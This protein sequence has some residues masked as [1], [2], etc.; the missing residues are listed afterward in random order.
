MEKNSKIIER[1]MPTKTIFRGLINVSYLSIGHFVS[2]AINL[3]GFIFIARLLGPNDYGIYITVGAF[4]GMFDIITFYGINK[5]VLREGAKDLSK[6]SDYLE[7]TTGVKNLFTFIAICICILS[8]FFTPY[9]TQI[10]IYIILFS[11]TLIYKS[12]NGFLAT[13]YKAA[14]KMQYNAILTIINRS[15]FVFIS[16]A[17][18][19]MGFGVLALFIVALFSEFFNLTINYKLTK[20]FL[21]FKF[22]NRITW[23]KYILKSALIFSILSFS[24]MLAG[25]ID[26]VMISILGSSK[27]VGIYGVAF[28]ITAVGL[29]TRELISTAFF[30]IFVKFYHKK[31]VTVRW[32]SLLKYSIMMGLGLLVIA[33]IISFYSEQIIS[34]LLGEEY[35]E[36]GTILSVLI[37]VVAI[38]Y[39]TIPF[40]NTLQATHNEIQL[41][42]ICWIAPSI[43]IGLNYLFFKVFGL[44]GIA[45][46]TLIVGCV[47]LILYILMTWR[48]LKK[49]NKLK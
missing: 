32:K 23:D 42:K 12:F 19:Y 18:L 22:W 47:A 46:S 30:P 20:K 24:F 26:L 16:I 14:E 9:S 4:V 7:R 38:A 45:Y 21:I 17:F 43:N 28:Q 5:V 10:K 1:L 31:S 35:F 11:F 40:T 44:I 36:S 2:M 6:M 27:D 37:F 33:T 3:I 15:M 13:V 25:K 29:V 49:Q 41:L 34:L 48:T 39:F 8:S